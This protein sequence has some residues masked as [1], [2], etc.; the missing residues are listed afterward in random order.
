[1]IVS[2][3]PAIC[4]KLYALLTSEPGFAVIGAVGGRDDA[5]LIAKGQ[6]PDIVI[7]DRLLQ[8]ESSIDFIE[9]LI[10]KARGTRVLFLT[11]EVAEE[12]LALSLGASGVIRRSADDQLF[13][14]IAEVWPSEVWR[15]E[16]LTNQMAVR[17]S[18]SVEAIK[19]ESLWGILRFPNP[20]WLAYA[21]T[22]MIL[23]AGFFVINNIREVEKDKPEL[24]LIPGFLAGIKE[25]TQTIRLEPY[26]AF[27]GDN[28]V[29]HPTDV[30]MSAPVVLL[31]LHLPKREIRDLQNLYDVSLI[32]AYDKELFTLIGLKCSEGENIPIRLSRQLIPK[33]RYRLA[34]SHGDEA[35][36]YYLFNVRNE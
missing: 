12:R 19:T 18:V 3:E 33:G 14:T 4:A 13:N 2:D 25:P 8:D 11:D 21:L 34:V 24:A 22:V 35:P 31:L 36:I 23:A 5:L 29:E 32:D 16:A 9:E 7:L 28:P 17:S 20:R 15:E 1:L 10:T 6:H 26:S 30:F 27:R